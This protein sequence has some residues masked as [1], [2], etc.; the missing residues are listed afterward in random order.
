[1]IPDPHPAANCGPLQ[2]ALLP[3]R[4]C[5]TCGYRVPAGPLDDRRQAALE[6]YFDEDNDVQAAIVTATRVKITEDI[7]EAAQQAGPFWNSVDEARPVL[8]AA[9]RAAGFEVTE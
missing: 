9:F 7:I 5:P 2:F 4:Q 1:M 3:G 6:T 8:T